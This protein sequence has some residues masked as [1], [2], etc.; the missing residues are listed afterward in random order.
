MSR[1]E[2]NY[3]IQTC[4]WSRECFDA[5]GNQIYTPAE[6]ERAAQADNRSC[7]SGVCAPMEHGNNLTGMSFEDF[8]RAREAYNDLRVSR[9][10]QGERNA[11]QVEVISVPVDGRSWIEVLLGSKR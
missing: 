6:L 10:A 2:M 4:G 5:A 11:R 8:T 1:S 9:L 7:P 3:R